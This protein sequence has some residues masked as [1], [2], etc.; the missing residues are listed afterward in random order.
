MKLKEAMESGKLS[1]LKNIPKDCEGN[2]V[3]LVSN[4][5]VFLHRF[6][7]ITGT[8]IGDPVSSSKKDISDEEIHEL[9]WRNRDI[10]HS[11]D[12]LCSCINESKK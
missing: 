11:I 8:D 9:N 2:S 12:S 4:L 5:N 3:T 1:F 7:D 6:R 10:E